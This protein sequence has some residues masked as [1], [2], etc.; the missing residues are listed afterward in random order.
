MS[1]NIIRPEVIK[2]VSNQIT[3]NS[4]EILRT[5]MR[6][7]LEKITEDFEE[8]EE[9]DTFGSDDISTVE[10]SDLDNAEDGTETAKEETPES[11]EADDETV[12][13]ENEWDD[14]SDFMV[15]DNEYDLTGADDE[16]AL[17][18]FKLLKGDDEIQV[19]K[20]DDGIKID[21][22]EDE[23]LVMNPEDGECGNCDTNEGELEIENEF[24]DDE[25]E[26]DEQEIAE[27]VESVIR[28]LTE[29]YNEESE[30]DLILDS[31]TEGE[32]EDMEI[33]SA[34]ARTSVTQTRAT[35]KPQTAID[36]AKDG[37]PV[38]QGGVKVESKE[39]KAK[40]NT[41]LEKY[42]Q[43]QANMKQALKTI[44]A[45]NAK[46]NEA[47]ITNFKLGRIV[48]LVTE[49][50]TNVEEKRNIIKRFTNEAKSI[51]DSTK[52]YESIS[53]ELKRKPAMNESFRKIDTQLGT[54]NPLNEQKNETK[55]TVL[56]LMERME[57]TRRK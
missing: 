1:K 34:G 12:E 51:D 29:S 45:Y 37:R 54:T 35:I 4:K 56:N 10:D 47:M 14:M 25:V 11:E 52:L 39:L 57:N 42:E 46:I 6:E 24:G 55:M 20:V 44:E 49:N 50:T 16:T 30:E 17:K 3:E 31:E 8:S 7:K 27:M 18:A 5:I 33:E 19:T 38:R 43:T 36:N 41:L 9:E 53:A 15:S 23:I 22:G 28:K 32:E 13:G 21:T 2:K 40:Y 26:V 48:K